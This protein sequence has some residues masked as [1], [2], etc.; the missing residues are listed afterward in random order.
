M[1]R[2]GRDG[3][4]MVQ[5]QEIGGTAR[6]M[7]MLLVLFWCA[8]GIGL[9]Y[10]AS[11]VDWPS[12][13]S[14]ARA[15]DPLW[16]ALGVGATLLA[17]PFWSLTWCL[18]G[19]VRL[20]HVGRLL[21]VQVVTLA[22]VQT[23]SLVAGGA[24][25]LVLLKRRAGLSTPAAA[26]LLAL[27]QLVTGIVKIL[28]VAMAVSLSHPPLW[29]QQAGVSLL[30]AIVVAVVGLLY[31][32]R[33]RET[34]LRLSAGRSGLRGVVLGFLG[35]AAQDLRALRDPWRS[36]AATGLM[37]L[38]RIVEGLT[39]LCVQKAVGIPVSWELGL[40]VITAL[41]LVTVIPQ[42][43]GNAGLYEAAVLVVYQAAG[44]PADLA[45]AAALLQHAAFL[46]AALVPGYAMV[47]VRQPWRARV[48][49]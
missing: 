8:L 44:I 48:T 21:E 36:A 40:L 39:V 25:A 5:E 46:V 37:L 34:L 2:S 11:F 16:L 30:A 3:V 13:L 18:L 28:L 17:L 1:K 43:P 9:L 42:P 26:S 4:K 47:L 35:H 12:V 22:A 24:T 41:A 31:A 49:S 29:M 6:R 32:Y 23:F 10:L 14:H 38:R 33:H 15:A 19:H 20:G 27:D 45:L 7:R